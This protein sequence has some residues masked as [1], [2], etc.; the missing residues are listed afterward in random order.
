MLK[1]AIATIALATSVAAANYKRVTC[2]DGVN[3]ATNEACCAFFALRD[4]LQNNLF[5]GECGEDVHESLRLTFHDAIGFSGSG[6]FKG[7]GADGSIILFSD[8]ELADPA[9]AGIDD[10]VH[11]IAPFLTRHNVTAG[12]L[13]QFAGA[14]GITNCPG[15]PR[16]EFL[17]GRPNATFPVD[18]GSVPLPQSPADLILSRMEDGGFSDAETIHLLVSHTIAR[19]D[20]LVPG[21]EAVPFDTTPFTFDPQIFLEVLLQGNGIPFGVNNT[22]GAE[23]DSPL[24]QSGEMRLQ[25]DFVLARDSRTA[26][27]WQSMVANQQ[28]MMQNFQSAM[29]KLAIVGH[30]RNQ[31]I[32]CSELIPSPIAPVSSAA[33]FPAGTSPD[34]VQQACAET[35]F[36]SL[37]ATGGQATQI[38]ACPDG[39]LN[40][41]DCP[42]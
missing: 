17:A 5:E 2:P 23:V 16:L 10:P 27:E 15:A 20:T 7:T 25:S 42:S 3:T 29:A 32:D 38:P 40:L 34:D 35:P 33:T 30:N 4:D 12:D 22:D 19:S 28:L 6:A 14:L 1:L 8:T 36:P 31:L 26:C 39:D 41:D 9:N 37:A 18:P 13:I 11:A 24:P 21:H